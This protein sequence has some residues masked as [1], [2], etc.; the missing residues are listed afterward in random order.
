[1]V[2]NLSDRLTD[3]EEEVYLFIKDHGEVLISNL[4]HRMMGAIPNLNNKGLIE[5]NKKRVTP[6]ASKKR[7]YVRVTEDRPTL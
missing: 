1:M 5:V 2:F 6:W 4:P 3:F 7:K